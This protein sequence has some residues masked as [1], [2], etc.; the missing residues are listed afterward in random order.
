MASTKEAEL[1]NRAV[2]IHPGELLELMYNHR[3]KLFMLDVRSE[4]DYDLF[5]IQNAQHVPM[6][7]LLATIYR[8]RLEPDNSVFVAISN[9]E[10]A[11]TEACQTPISSKAESTTG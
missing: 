2:Q 5:H 6:D 11:A 1:N 7:T 9:D 4:T 3:I 10:K 8:L